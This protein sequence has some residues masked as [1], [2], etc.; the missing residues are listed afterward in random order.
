MPVSWVPALSL[1]EGERA[2]RR[3]AGRAGQGLQERS[4]CACAAAP[5]VPRTS[6]AWIRGAV[7]AL[8]PLS[9]LQPGQGPNQSGSGAVRTVFPRDQQIASEHS[10][11]KQ[12]EGVGAIRCSL[13]LLAKT[14]AA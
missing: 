5:D 7:E 10:T 1:G 6:Q 13:N 9:R 3:R 4:G 14:A 11:A 2:S 12:G 8:E